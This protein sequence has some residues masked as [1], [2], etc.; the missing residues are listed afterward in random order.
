MA[1]S[2][3]SAMVCYDRQER[4]VNSG[5]QKNVPPECR[6]NGSQVFCMR[7]KAELGEK[8]GPAAKSLRLKTDDYS[9]LS[10]EMSPRKF[11]KSDDAAHRVA[12]PLVVAALAGGISLPTANSAP[13]R[14]VPVMESRAETVGCTSGGGPPCRYSAF[15]IPGLV[16]AGNNTLIAFAEGRKYGCGDFGPFPGGGI[17]FHGN[18]THIPPAQLGKGQHDLVARRSTDG[19]QHSQ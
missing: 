9:R 1:L 6:I 10:L 15:R 16:N 13:V 14:L 19:N 8:A 7:F 11:I 2:R 18:L 5:G 17:G 3:D 4:W 12:W